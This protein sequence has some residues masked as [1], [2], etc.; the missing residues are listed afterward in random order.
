MFN[1]SFKRLFA[2]AKVMATREFFTFGGVCHLGGDL[3]R[4]HK[5]LGLDVA[6]YTL[7]RLLLL[8]AVTAHTPVFFKKN[9][10]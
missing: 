10:I 4:P 5:H 3:L 2:F 1:L 7:S 8:C 9:P 6:H